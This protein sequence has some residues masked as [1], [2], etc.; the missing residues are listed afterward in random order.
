MTNEHY[1]AVLGDLESQRDELNVAISALRRAMGLADAE[2]A[3]NVATGRRQSL[4]SDQMRPD[5]FFNMSIIDAAVKYLS[6]MKK[7]A[8]AP[9]IAQALKAHGLLN[10]SKTFT[11]TVYSILY[12]ESQRPDGRVVKV[13]NTNHWGLADWYP[14]AAAAR[15]TNGSTSSGDQPTESEQPDEQSQSDA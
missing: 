3:P 12:R 9:N 2:D 13:A 10:E 8:P 1:E 7:P 14:K 15:R 5:E 6:I 4:R 11:S